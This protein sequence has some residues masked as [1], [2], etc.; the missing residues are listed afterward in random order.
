MSSEKIATHKYLKP[1]RHEECITVQLLTCV[2]CVNYGTDVIQFLVLLLM[3]SI[4]DETMSDNEVFNSATPSPSYH[5]K[6]STRTQRSRRATVACEGLQQSCYSTGDIPS[7]AD[8]E[9]VAK[10]RPKSFFPTTG[11]DLLN[12]N[13]LQKSDS[14]NL[15]EP[16]SK[17]GMVC[18]LDVFVYEMQ[19][20]PN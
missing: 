13:Q 11:N 5:A 9:N 7:L 19:I 2:S 1:H 17:A 20:K 14:S 8:Q 4:A 3:C 18:W 10:S 6:F 16:A 15:S 12:W